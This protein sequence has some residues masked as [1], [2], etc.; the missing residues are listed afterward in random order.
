MSAAVW[1]LRNRFVTVASSLTFL[2]CSVAATSIPAAQMTQMLMTALWGSDCIGIARSWWGGRE[3]PARLRRWIASA[4]YVPRPRRSLAPTPPT[5]SLTTLYRTHWLHQGS[6]R[7]RAAQ[8][9]HVVAGH[10][11]YPQS[12]PQCAHRRV[13]ELWKSAKPL[14]NSRFLRLVWGWV[15]HRLSTIIHRRCG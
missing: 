6:E 12:C 14:K 15:I 4:L 13:L 8:P 11:G 5:P 10:S 1:R 9:L 2:I 7:F 3:A